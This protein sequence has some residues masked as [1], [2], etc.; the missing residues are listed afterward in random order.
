MLLGQ[1]GKAGGGKTNNF[2]ATVT[3]TK[4]GGAPADSSVFTSQL[5][6]VAGVIK[7]GETNQMTKLIFRLSRG[8]VATFFE[9]IGTVGDIADDRENSR[10]KTGQ[11]QPTSYAAYVLVFSESDYLL[12][13]VQRIAQSFSLNTYTMPK[14]QSN[15]D[16]IKQ[17]AELNVEIAKAKDL[18]T[19][20]RSRLRDYLASI[21]VIDQHEQYFDG[22]DTNAVAANTA[23]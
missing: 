5:N 16:R 3:A 15:Q 10:Q 11:V 21:Q 1:G 13:K 2:N 9:N 23:A 20:T 6:V 22:D 8:K 18:L 7:E 17:V 14:G 12:T 19:A 4:N